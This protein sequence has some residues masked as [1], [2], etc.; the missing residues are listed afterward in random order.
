MMFILQCF[1]PDV[2][3]KELTDRHFLLL[4]DSFLYMVH[5]SLRSFF[6]EVTKIVRIR[7]TFFLRKRSP[8]TLSSLLTL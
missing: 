6:L 8:K 3:P 1:R 4:S 5:L 7:V 2:I